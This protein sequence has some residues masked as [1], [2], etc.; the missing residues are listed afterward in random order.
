MAEKGKMMAGEE[1][2]LPRCTIKYK[3][4]PN[5]PMKVVEWHGKKNIKVNP[6]R[7]SPEITD[8]VSQKK[9]GGLERKDGE[10][11]VAW[12]KGRRRGGCERR[13]GRRRKE[14]GGGER[15]VWG[16]LAVTD[17]SLEEACFRL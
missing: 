6:K 16:P 4:N 7:P 9:R 13:R 5:K 17:L 3:E 14:R 1:E 2:A 8:P 11:G 10:G 15:Q 12:R